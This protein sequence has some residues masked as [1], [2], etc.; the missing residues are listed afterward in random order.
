VKAFVVCA[1]LLFACRKAEAPDRWADVEKLAT[2]TVTAADGALLTK[3]LDRVTNDDVPEMALEDAIAWRKASGGLPWRGG[4]TIEDP[5]ALHTMRLGSA[6]LDRRGDDPE[7]VL[8][9]LYLAQRLRAEAPALIDVTIGFTLAGKA[10]TKPWRAEY[11]PFAPTEA[12]VLRAIPADAVHF[13][14]ALKEM[15]NDEQT[16][17]KAIRAAYTAMLVGAPRE[18]AAYVKH[19]GAE[20]AK[21][22]KSDVMSIVISPK[23]PTLADEMF[24]AVETYKKWS[25]SM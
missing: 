13:S 17:G 21:A 18:R 14:T 8:T 24:E 4:R 16:I 10:T 1:F 15:P 23:L 5:R 3:A 25:R 9:V 22:Q 11:A 19:I 12:E 20:S 6:L 2:P 7:A